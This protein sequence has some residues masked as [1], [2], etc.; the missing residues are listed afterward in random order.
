MPLGL[1]GADSGN[2][3]GMSGLRL[4]HM[5]QEHEASYETALSFVAAGDL[6]VFSLLQKSLRPSA[7]RTSKRPRPTIKN[8]IR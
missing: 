2:I 7:L 1:L 8:S 6:A 5:A 4:A 3:R